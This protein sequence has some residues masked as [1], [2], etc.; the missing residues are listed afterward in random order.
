MTMAINIPTG[1]VPLKH[2]TADE[3]ARSGLT[4]CAVYNRFKR[5]RYNNLTVMRL[6]KRVI[7]IK[8]NPGP[9]AGQ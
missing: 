3:A 2:W 8:I 4:Q 7:F 5:G 6:N 9:A 1:C